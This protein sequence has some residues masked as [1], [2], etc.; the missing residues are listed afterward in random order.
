MFFVKVT[1]QILLSTI[2]ATFIS[3][4]IY[5]SNFKCHAMFPVFGHVHVHVQSTPPSLQIVKN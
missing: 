4:T 2:I 5:I 3:T 1:Y